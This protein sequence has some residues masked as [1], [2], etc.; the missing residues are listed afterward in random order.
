MDKK[1]TTFRTKLTPVQLQQRLIYTQSE[2][3]KY[4]T[5]VERYQNDYYYNMID[6][7]KDKEEKWTQEKKELEEALEFTNQT[8][9]NLQNEVT[10]LKQQEKAD[11]SSATKIEHTTNHAVT[12]E[13]DPSPSKEITIDQDHSSVTQTK[14]Q[15]WFLRSVRDKKED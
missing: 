9:K 4:K 13:T 12:Q 10:K 8:I 11:Q 5:Q 14:N 7:F 1:P 2:L 3:N 6:E 15:D